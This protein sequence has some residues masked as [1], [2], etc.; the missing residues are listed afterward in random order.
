MANHYDKILRENISEVI[1]PISKKYFGFEI[2]ET[3]DLPSTLQVT[4]G[5]EPDF[6][7][8]VRTTTGDEFILH[9]E[10][11]T[12]S[13]ANMIYR[14]M[15]YHA[16]L[17]ETYR[18]KVRQFVLYFGKGEPQMRSQLKEE[19]VMRG[20]ELK[21][22]SDFDHEQLVQSAIP[23]EIILAVLSDFKGRDPLAVIR[24]ILERLR[25]VEPND[26]AL[27]KA[28][29]QLGMLSRLR[30]L[31]EEVKKESKNMPITY[32]IATDKFY[33]EG[34]EEGKV[35]GKIEGKIEGKKEGIIEGKL[36]EKVATAITMLKMG[37]YGLPEIA[38]VT[39]LDIKKVSELK[40][41]LSE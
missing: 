24:L 28:L 10:Y 41:K 25:K 38:L 31:Y 18:K 15:T 6:I 26:N 19:E 40:E 3:E 9:L 20:F 27:H 1:L 21:N 2:L 30:N 34:K 33:Q 11:Q 7:K 36:K 23:E 5:R 12:T 39:G 22:I 4:L 32:N 37:K 29:Q 35:E 13:D 14:M 8:L 16:L 17:M